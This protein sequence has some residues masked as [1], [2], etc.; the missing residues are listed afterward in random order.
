MKLFNKSEFI[1]ISI[2]V[3]AQS[4][5]ASTPDILKL[6]DRADVVNR[7]LKARFTDILPDV[8]VRTEIDMWII[9]CREYNEDPVFPT[10]VPAP[11]LSARRLTMLVFYNKGGG[12]V[13][14][15]TVSK[16]DMGEY[17]T[18]AWNSDVEDQWDVLKKIIADRNPKKIGVNIGPMF[19][20]GDGLSVSL[21]E[22]LVNSLGKEYASR[23]CS[24]EKL[25]VGWLETRH[26][27]ELE[28][29]PQITAIAHGIIKTAF[30]NKVITPGVTTTEDVVWW[31]RQRIL[32]LGLQTWFQPSVSI[33]RNES[34]KELAL[35][36]DVI[37]RGDFLH[38]DI[39]V[40]Y[41]RLNTDTQEQAY[42]LKYG[43][44]DIPENLKKA[45]KLGNDLQDILT[46]E[47][48]TGLTGNEIL[49]TSLN[50]AK[51]AGLNP[52]IYTHPLG[53]HGHAAGPTIGLWDQQGGVPGGGDYPL[54]PNTCHSIE[55]NI[56][57]TLPDWNNQEIRIALEQDAVFTG[58][59]VYYLDGRQTAI[60]I[61][62]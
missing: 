21:H 44:A 18:H 25:A 59:T 50:K 56:K 57:T 58:K 42:V 38:C 7:I 31:I 48:K 2:I 12:E 46:A 28:I 61:I 5:I 37:Q 39:G 35:S 43:E 32:D 47:F 30:S 23:I 54:Y 45:F 15:L 53:Y 29:Y 40:K 22:K 34:A 60:H 11:T 27:Q 10:I 49:L 41:L 20:F 52:S 8:M 6:R 17:Y 16:Y 9:M 51:A 24:A 13:E 55:L 3:I 62:K 4:L 19:A 26:P 14:R 1:I 36:A 33:A